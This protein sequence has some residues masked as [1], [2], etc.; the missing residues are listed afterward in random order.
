MISYRI[1]DGN[2]I[3]FTIESLTGFPIGFLIGNLIGFRNPIENHIGIQWKSYRKGLT[4]GNPN[5]TGTYE[6]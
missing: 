5:P 1:F 2:S 4:M 6:L 3:G